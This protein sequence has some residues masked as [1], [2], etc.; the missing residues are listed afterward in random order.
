MRSVEVLA[1]VGQEPRASEIWVCQE[2]RE[3]QLGDERLALRLA[4]VVA[5]LAEH[6]ACSVLG[7]TRFGGRVPG[8][9]V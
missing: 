4:R 8:W 2:L 5:T 1:P 7:L 9:L 3:A 6:P